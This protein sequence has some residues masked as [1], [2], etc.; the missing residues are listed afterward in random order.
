LSQYF[1][2]YTVSIEGAFIAF[3]YCFLWG[4]LFGWLF[5]YLRNFFLAYFIFR[6]KRA[7]EQLTVMDFFDHY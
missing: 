2:G 3:G 4:F 5:A 6:S 1:A 7:S